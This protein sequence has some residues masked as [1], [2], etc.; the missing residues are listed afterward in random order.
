MGFDFDFKE[1]RLV[2]SW[3]LDATAREIAL[4]LI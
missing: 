1:S 3:M 4:K 2:G